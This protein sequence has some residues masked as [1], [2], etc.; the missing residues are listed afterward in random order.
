MHGYFSMVFTIFRS[1][2]KINMVPKKILVGPESLNR[3]A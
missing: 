3:A 1:V 2:K